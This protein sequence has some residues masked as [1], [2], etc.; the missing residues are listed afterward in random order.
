MMD[1]VI[2]SACVAGFVSVTTIILSKSKCVVECSEDH[3]CCDGCC[4]EWCRI[5]FLDQPLKQERGARPDDEPPPRS[6]DDH[7]FLWAR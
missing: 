3:R 1:P 2:T 4:C 5:G 6:S 7:N